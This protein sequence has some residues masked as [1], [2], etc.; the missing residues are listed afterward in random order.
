MRR[1][2]VIIKKNA[3]ARRNGSY[4]INSI[5]YI[6]FQYNGIKTNVFTLNGSKFIEIGDLRIINYYIYKFYLLVY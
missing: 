6:F 2:S 5:K 1:R 4:I 3:I